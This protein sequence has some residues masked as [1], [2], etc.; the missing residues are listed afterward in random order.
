MRKKDMGVPGWIQKY[1]DAKDLN[2]GLCVLILAAGSGHRMNS[3][4]PL[5]WP[6]FPSY[7]CKPESPAVGFAF[8]R[9][10]VL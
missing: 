7:S 10:S 3:D 1:K 4:L 6:F 2:Q 8:Y 9:H 5:V